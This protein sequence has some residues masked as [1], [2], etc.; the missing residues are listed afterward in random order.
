MRI[1]PIS[2]PISRLFFTALLVCFSPGWAQTASPVASPLVSPLAAP[3]APPLAAPTQPGQATLKHDSKPD[4]KPGA[5]SDPKT[6]LPIAGQSATS[7]HQLIERIH[8][9]GGTSNIDELR[10][11]GETRSI[12]VQPKGGMPAYDVQPVTGTRAWK[13]LGF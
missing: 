4:I 9:E 6:D 8:V 11:G 7:T 13:V 1:A 2:A 10:V 3:P 12:T 5:K